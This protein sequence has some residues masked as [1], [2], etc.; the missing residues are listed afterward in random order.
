MREIGEAAVTALRLLWSADP[1]LVAIVAL[2]LE[3]SLTATALAAAIGLQI[4]GRR[5]DDLGVLQMARAFERL[6][7]PLPPWPMPRGS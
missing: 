2:S 7:A 6:R 3:V 4:V 1:E 5:F